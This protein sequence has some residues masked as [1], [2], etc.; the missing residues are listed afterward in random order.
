MFSVHFSVVQSKPR[1]QPYCLLVTRLIE[2]E[3]LYKTQRYVYPGLLPVVNTVMIFIGSISIMSTVRLYDRTQ[4]WKCYIIFSHSKD[5]IVVIFSK[6]EH[7]YCYEPIIVKCSRYARVWGTW[8]RIKPCTNTILIFIIMYIMY[9]HAVQVYCKF[10]LLR[11]HI[12][13]HNQ[14][15]KFRRSWS[16][17]SVYSCN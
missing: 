11:K 16:F 5:N 17:G 9:S 15:K 10:C 2:E 12:D 7:Q 8:G 3:R 6:C 13:S 4:T 1:R 14:L